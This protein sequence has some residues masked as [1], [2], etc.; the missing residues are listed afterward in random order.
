MRYYHHMLIS[1]LES[2][3]VGLWYEILP[4]H[5]AAAMTRFFY[6]FCIA[7]VMHACIIMHNSMIESRIKVKVS[8]I[9]ATRT[10]DLARWLRCS[11]NSP[12]SGFTS[13]L[14]EVLVATTNYNGRGTSVCSAPTR[15]DRRNLVTLPLKLICTFFLVCFSLYFFG[16][17][18]WRRFSYCVLNFMLF[19]YFI[20]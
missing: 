3:H 4:S 20:L 17:L 16:I 8:P 12:K 10:L 19:C 14:I 7:D 13:R 18:I 2:G 5:D 6:K 11:P 1:G 15:Y 9:R